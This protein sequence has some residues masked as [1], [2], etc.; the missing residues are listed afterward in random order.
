MSHTTAARSLVIEELKDEGIGY[1]IVLVDAL[2]DL[3]ISLLKEG[4]SNG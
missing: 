3:Y 2:L 4:E 1:S